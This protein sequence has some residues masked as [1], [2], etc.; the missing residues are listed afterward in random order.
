MI[1][2][3]TNSIK[4]MEMGSLQMLLFTRGARGENGEMGSEMSTDFGDFNN[5]VFL[6]LIVTNFQDEI[7][8]LYKNE[9]NGFFSD[10]TYISGIG[11]KT[12]STPRWGTAFS[13]MIMTV[14]RTF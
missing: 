1:L 4:M 11:E 12:L 2:M 14:L 6:D 3:I 10:I 8:I 5:D 9:G 7:T 13:I